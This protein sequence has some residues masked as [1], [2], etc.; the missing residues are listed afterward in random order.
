MVT[1]SRD[2]TTVATQALYLLNDPLVRRQSL[3]LADRLLARTDCDDAG[4]VDWAYRLTVGRAA[5]AQETA[6]ALAYL[7]DYAAASEPILAAQPVPP[8]PENAVAAADSSTAGAG[9]E[10][11]A[12]KKPAQKKPAP[13]NPD[14]ADQSDGP[15]Q[16]EV[17]QPASAKAAA[18]AS[19]CQA[20]FGS[21]EFR[22]LK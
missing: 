21:A 14:E 17:I 16:E 20:L 12:A 13:Q 9:G 7:A 19:F 11:A 10:S 4:R 1:G 5:T 8:Q 2:T 6:R 18:W 3:V 15:V 22:Y